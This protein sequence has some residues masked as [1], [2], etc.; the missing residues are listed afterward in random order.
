MVSMSSSGPN[1]LVRYCAAPAAKPTAR[2]LS[3]SWAV[4]ITVGMLAAG[5][6]E[7][8]LPVLGLD[9][10]PTLRREGDLHHLADR[11]EVIS[12]Q[13]LR[14]VKRTFHHGHAG[15]DD[16]TVGGTPPPH[17]GSSLDFLLAGG[18]AVAAPRVQ[19]DDAKP[20]GLGDGLEAGS[21]SAPPHES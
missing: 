17:G 8:L 11:N 1:G 15:N 16:R 10:R 13:Q 19:G 2:S 18:R 14:H 4:S 20:G 3:L 12:D 5:Q 7:G 21:G 9:D 6:V